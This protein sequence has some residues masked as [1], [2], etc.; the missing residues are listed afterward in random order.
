M[1]DTL[2]DRAPGDRSTRPDAEEGTSAGV[3]VY[4]I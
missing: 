1:T 2:Y 3:L 4:T